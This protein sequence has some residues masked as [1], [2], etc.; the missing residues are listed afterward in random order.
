MHKE[1]DKPK[2]LTDTM[3]VSANPEALTATVSVSDQPESLNCHSDS[4]NQ[5]TAAKI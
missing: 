1:D 5:L 2:A 4:L 3:A